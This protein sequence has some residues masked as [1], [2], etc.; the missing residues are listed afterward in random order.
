MLRPV[1]NAGLIAMWAVITVNGHI[2][3]E[4]V[5]TIGKHV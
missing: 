2:T 4:R 3:T 1:W 5:M